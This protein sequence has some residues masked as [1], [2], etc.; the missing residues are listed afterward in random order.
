M[1]FN[2]WYL[3]SF[4]V[5]F[6]VAIPILTVFASFFQETT[7]YYD[8]LKNTFLIEY[9]H[10]SLTL[11]IG[12]LILTLVLGVGC[13]Y[14]VSFYDFPGV[15]F[16][17]WALILSF[18]VPAYIYAYSLTAFFENFGT[19]YSILKSLFGPGEYNQSIPKFDG[20]LGAILSISFSLFGYVYVLTRASFHYQ[21]QNLIELGQNL[22][23]S[24]YKSFFKIILPSAR[25]AIVAGLALVAMETLSDFGAV[26][27]FGIA[28]LTTG[29]YDSW[30]SFD[31][32]AFA[33]QLSFFLLLFILGLFFIENISRKKAQY[34]SP[35]KGGIKEKKKIKLNFSKETLA[36]EFLLL[37]FLWVIGFANFLRSIPIQ[38]PSDIVKSD[39]IIVLTGGSRRLEVGITLLENDKAALLFVSG[40]NEKVTRSDILNLLDGGKL[41]K[42]AKLFNCCITLGYIA[43][44]TRGNARESLQWVREN[45]LS[46]IILVT[47]NYHMQR[48]YLEFKSQNPNIK[49]TQYPVSNGEFRLSSWL[50]H[51]KRFV[52]LF[53][54]FH[55]LILTNL[56]AYCCYP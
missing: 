30:I 55:K 5:S 2:S 10:N 50:T 39:A 41:P 47:S 23:F 34:H 12:V 32:L 13:A 17:K 6:V 25:P 21:S 22:G 51:S 49:I 36:F 33:N 26:S 1:K 42:S 43:E 8:I 3:S 7:N 40:V 45:S 9:N 18:A 54:V 15:K 4:L 46:S 20:M 56:R 31:D 48:A 29:I 52:L 37:V 28:T 14:V 44:D 24:K 16:F 53:L 35:V 19:L 38:P 11:L 27:F